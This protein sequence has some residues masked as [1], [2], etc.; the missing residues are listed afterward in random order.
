MKKNSVAHEQRR[1]NEVGYKVNPGAIIEQPMLKVDA[2]HQKLGGEHNGPNENLGER[3]LR[4]LKY[5]PVWVNDHETKK[6]TW[7]QTQNIQPRD[8][9]RPVLPLVP[10]TQFKL[11]RSPLSGQ[12][13]VTALE[14]RKIVAYIQKLTPMVATAEIVK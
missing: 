3:Y 10:E 14:A 4:D 7:E 1:L 9:R 6:H 12:D 13:K 8:D 2:K 11:A 5:P